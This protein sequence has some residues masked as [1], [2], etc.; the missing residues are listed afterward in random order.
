[1]LP[2]VS[3]ATTSIRRRLSAEKLHFS[4]RDGRGGVWVHV[5]FDGWLACGFLSSDYLDTYVVLTDATSQT[6]LPKM[7]SSCTVCDRVPVHGHIQ[8]R[9]LYYN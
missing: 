9:D 7:I 1:M 8:E 5:S 4:G 2:P 6:A 3:A